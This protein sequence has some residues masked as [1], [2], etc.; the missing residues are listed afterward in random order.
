MANVSADPATAQQLEERP[1]QRHPRVQVRMKVRLSTIDPE[2]DP[3]TGKT[4][5]RHS[6]ETCANVSL[7]GAFVVTKETI[8]PG[9]RVLLEFELPAGREV[10]TTARVAWTKTAMSAGSP[11]GGPRES[12]I[13]VEFHG[14]ARAQ[15]LELE[16]FVAR[17]LRRRHLTSEASAHHTRPA[18]G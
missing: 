8:P 10:Q 15:L 12:G 5:Y 14:G 3:W 6:E 11:A 13:G 2:T 1:I 16:R 18:R 4:F 17:S 7:S 9:R